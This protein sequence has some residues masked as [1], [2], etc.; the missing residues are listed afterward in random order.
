MSAMV[1]ICKKKGAILPKNP[2]RERNVMSTA[3]FGLSAVGICN[4]VK[5]PK[6][7]KYTGFRPNVSDKG[8]SKSLPCPDISK[9][10][11]HPS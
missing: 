3:I 8:A 10:S 9:I 4:K 6:Q 5:M 1:E 2:A 11:N 7:V